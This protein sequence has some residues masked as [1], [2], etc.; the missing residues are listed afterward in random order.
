[1]LILTSILSPMMSVTAENSLEASTDQEIS[2][3][4]SREIIELKFIE[5]STFRL[6]EGMLTTQ[7][8]DDLIGIN[9]V[10]AA[11]SVDRIE[12]LFS[13]PEEE[14]EAERAD[15]LTRTGE[16]IP[17]L[18]LWYRFWVPEGEDIDD[19]IKALNALPEVQT[20]YAAPLPAQPLSIEL[21]TY[22]P[23]P[24]TP[25]A[26]PNY[27]SNQG[28]L[29]AAPGGID[30][31]YAWTLAGGK[32]Q[33]VQI[34]DVEY[35]WNGSHVDLPSI[36]LVNGV[37]YL[38]YGDDHGTAVQGELV[39]KKD[40]VGVS[41]IAYQAVSKFSSPCPNSACSGYN[42]AG[43]INAAQT[44]T[45]SGD[46]ILIE[47]Q[48]GVCGTSDYGPLEWIQSVYDAIKVATTTGRIVVEAAGNGNVNLDGAS[49]NNLFNRS[50]RDSGAII[51]GAG[52]APTGTQTARSRLSFSSYG[53]RVDVQGWGERVYT[54]GYG[55]LYSGTGK[56]E[57]YTATFGGTS[58]AS[59]IVAGAAALLS[60]VA[61]ARGISLTPFQIRS[62]L[63]STGS[64]QQ[65]ATGFPVTQHIG[66]L[67]NVK[68]AI[69]T[70]G[71]A[72]VP[73]PIAP[74]VSVA[75]HRPTYKWS[76]VPNA[77]AYI[78]QVYQGTTKKFAKQLPVGICSSGTC[79]F[80]PKWIL[81]DGN[82]KWR[83]RAK[84]GGTWRTFS[85]F[86]NFN[87]ATE[88]HYQFTLPKS[89]DRWNVAFGPWSL[90]GG[91]YRSD[92][93]SPYWNSA[94]HN[95]LYPTLSFIVS[96]RR[97]NTAGPNSLFVRGTPYPLASNKY[98]SDGYQFSYANNGVF[99]VWKMIDG[100]YTCLQPWTSTPAINQYDWNTLKVKAKDNILKF[101]INN[102]LVWSGTDSTYSTGKVGV[103]F[104]KGDSASQAFAM[105]YAHLYTY[106]PT[107]ALE[108]DVWAELGETNFE[109][110]NP[111]IV[112]HAP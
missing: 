29:N 65:A 5:G 59:P 81:A 108:T 72:N 101:Y 1:M 50:N 70:L 49:C 51:V 67:P 32:G 40:G 95:G 15:L 80:T 100:N 17:D 109:W 69:N 85:A 12:R 45:V 91:K 18:N 13:Q 94:F 30:A 77:Q 46:V 21:P 52:A 90:S 6:R 11:F 10:V 47:Q 112:P 71:A 22:L 63:V 2:P 111:L 25:P 73:V 97:F 39:A 75:T 79:K 9:G 41:G 107:I 14:I 62:K 64:P 53:S 60:S 57:W 44:N 38:G 58:S 43:A 106:V 98:W 61:Q 54:T 33:N 99:G 48:T 92:G 66:P 35:S 74:K 3:D 37:Q 96:M 8:P 105:D 36:S 88:F 78:V 23:D 27:E 28:Y 104:Y 83:V 89:L 84:V 24:D 19:L 82:Y 110:D 68:A 86:T 34:V 102:Q 31:K 76:K 20:A 55:S 87:V 16:A 56:N 42:P 7:Q 26:I 4:A 93:L 103:G